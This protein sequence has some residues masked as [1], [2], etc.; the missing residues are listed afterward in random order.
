MFHG[1]YV[2]HR[3]AICC[4]FFRRHLSAAENRPPLNFRPIF[5][6]SYITFRVNLHCRLA[7]RE[8]SMLICILKNTK[9][10]EDNLKM[11]FYEIFTGVRS[12]QR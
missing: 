10:R 8:V 9:Q 7:K 4:K 12:M 3:A 1:A 11:V 5:V 6:N 2:V